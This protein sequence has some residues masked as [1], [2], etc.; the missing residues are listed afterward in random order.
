MMPAMQVALSETQELYTSRRVTGFVLHL[1]DGVLHTIPN[2]KS[3][4]LPHAIIV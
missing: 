4:T 2:N 1:C 3:Y